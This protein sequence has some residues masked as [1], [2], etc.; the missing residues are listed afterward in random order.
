MEVDPNSEFGMSKIR[1]SSIGLKGIPDEWKEQ[2]RA[3]NIPKEMAMKH[4]DA[5]VD[6]LSYVMKA[7]EPAPLQ[8]TQD[9]EKD[10]DSGIGVFHN[11]SD[12][13]F[14]FGCRSANGLHKY[15]KT[16]WCRSFGNCVRTNHSS[17]WSV[18]I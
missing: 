2:L 13:C 1:R 12:S 11:L 18:V 7:P 10:L 4:K 6:V 8:A 3:A 14:Y 17:S 15:L 16:S 9:F 5:I